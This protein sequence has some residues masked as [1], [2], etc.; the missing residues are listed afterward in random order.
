MTSAPAA[1][2]PVA[3]TSRSGHDESVHFGAVVALDHDGGVAL[4]VGSPDVAI[5]PRSSCKP[6]QATAMVRAG[7]ALPPEL[8]ALACASH[9]GT[10]HHCAG[11]ERLLASA[12][13]SPA[14]LANT[15]DLPLDDASAQAVLRAGGGRTP[16]TQN[17]SGKHAA[18]VAT[19]VA[20][21]WVHEAGAYLDPSH[22]L[23][24]AIT[25][26][27]AGLTGD[28]VAHIGVD[29]CGAPAHVCTLLGLADAYRRIATGEA[30]P[31]GDAVYAA[32]TSHPELVGG[33]RRDVTAFMRF[34]PGLMAKDGAEGVFAAALPDGR[35]VALKIADGASRARPAVMVAA[36]DALGI[37]TSDAAP[38]VRQV[39]R[40]H[41]R[42]VGEVR[43]L[44]AP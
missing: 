21:G 7:V 17:C 29:G 40:G 13:L 37:D 3:V 22:P 25:A 39:V 44:L 28:D 35:A 41:G 18:M 16:L 12:G 10:P 36:L 19:C 20:N 6:L 2:V 27:I 30:G 24:V 43:A 15:P 4:S 8:L 26:A 38:E 42:E 31:A 34:V 14:A 23:Q 1:Y 9:D 11:V 32:M 5:Y 33:E